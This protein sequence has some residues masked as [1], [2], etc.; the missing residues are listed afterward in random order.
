MTTREILQHQNNYISNPSDSNLITLI[1][2]FKPLY[3]KIISIITNKTNFSLSYSKYGEIWEEVEFLLYEYYL[4]RPDFYIE[5]PYTYTYKMTWNFLFNRKAQKKDKMV[6]DS[7]ILDFFAYDDEQ[8][9]IINNTFLCQSVIT[10]LEHQIQSNLELSSINDK[11]AAETNIKAFIYELQA[12]GKD[13]H[14]R[15]YKLKVKERT[16]FIE[17]VKATRE[18]MYEKAVS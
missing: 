16:I 3:A 6:Y 11:T 18:K 9:D 15:L 8:F 12:D 7:E 4:G 13:Y 1:N 5:N 2:C 10:E 17:A 14:K